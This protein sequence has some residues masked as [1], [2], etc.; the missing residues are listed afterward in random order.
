[1]ALALSHSTGRRERFKRLS[2]F[3]EN[4][5]FIVASRHRGRRKSHGFH[6][7]LRNFT[8]VLTMGGN[9]L[10]GFCS[11]SRLNDTQLSLPTDALWRIKLRKVDARMPQT[12]AF[13]RSRDRT[14]RYIR[15][16]T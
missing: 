7:D 6:L 10:S 9:G 3:I 2:F 8:R 11:L 1:M 16:I 13:L 5:L 14:G 4:A 15:D 12:R